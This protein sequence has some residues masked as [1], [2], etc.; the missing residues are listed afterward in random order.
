MRRGLKPSET[1]YVASGRDRR[2]LRFSVSGED[3][4]ERAYGTHWVSPELTPRPYYPSARDH[5][6]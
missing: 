3:A 5:Q 4:I 1:A 6:E 2:P